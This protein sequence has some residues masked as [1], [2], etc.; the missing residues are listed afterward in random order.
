MIVVL[1]SKTA[2]CK[3][4][5]T[6]NGAVSIVAKYSKKF[7]TSLL[8]QLVVLSQ[9][10]FAYNDIVPPQ[11]T[12]DNPVNHIVIDPN[13]AGNAFIDR[14]QNGTPVVNINA[15]SAGGVSANYYR[16][17]NVN[18]ENL[19][20]NN[21][22]GEAG[23]SQL[24]GALHGNPNF[25]IPG[26][27]AADIILNEVTSNRV[28]NINGYTEVFGKT[29]EVIIAN[30]NGIMVGGAGFINT[31]RLSLITGQSNGLNTYGGL[32][33]FIISTSPNAVISV[34]GRDVTDKDGNPVAY[35]LGIDM[36]DGNYMDLISRVVEINGKLLASDEINIKTGNDKAIRTANGWD[37]SSNDKESE[38]EFVI[39]STAMGGIYAGRINLIATQAGVGVR[40]RG[41]V[42]SNISDVKF[43]ADGNIVV[44]GGINSA[45]NINISTN[46]DINITGKNV[47]ANQDIIISS[48]KNISVDT[49]I[50][51]NQNISFD[52]VN[53]LTVSSD[54]SAGNNLT[55]NAT[56]TVN[57]GTIKANNFAKLSSNTF[58]NDGGKLVSVKNLD[59]NLGSNDWISGGILQANTLNL[60]A[61]TITNVNAEISAND[62]NI[63][64]DGDFINGDTGISTILAATNDMTLN[65][66]GNITNIGTIK[67]DNNLNITVGNGVYNGLQ[68]GDQA[69]LHSGGNLII[70]ANNN[71]LNKGFIQALGTLSMKTQA[72]I[73]DDYILIPNA[74]GLP[75][76]EDTVL[77]PEWQEVYDK[78]DDTT[79]IV[80]L[81]DLLNNVKTA[82]QYY[83]VQ[84][85]LRL[86][87]IEN[88][89]NEQETGIGGIT[90]ENIAT[91]S[92]GELQSVLQ[93]ILEEN[94]VAKEW[95]IDLTDQAADINSQI[96]AQQ[97]RTDEYNTV[98]EEI[99]R[100]EYIAENG[101]DTGFVYTH[102]SRAEYAEI[103]NEEYLDF[104]TLLAGAESEAKQKRLEQIENF[105][106]VKQDL[107]EEYKSLDWASMDDSE[108]YDKLSI[109]LETDYN[110]A[111]WEIRLYA[112][113]SMDLNN[114]YLNALR[115][116]SINRNIV[117]Q[118]GIH[119]DGRIYSGGNM[120]LLSNSVLHNNK[121]ALIFS[122]SDAE[123]SVQNTLFNNTNAEGQGIFVDGNLS[124]SGVESSWLDT[125][126]NY[127][128]KIESNGNL[129]INA[130]DV[131]NYGSDSIDFSQ[132]DNSIKEA[133]EYRHYYREC[134]LGGTYPECKRPGSSFVSSTDSYF[135]RE[136]SRVISKD[137]YDQ[138]LAQGEKVT[139]TF[140]YYYVE[141]YPE[142]SAAYT[143]TK[144]NIAPR[145]NPDITV[146]TDI[147]VATMT[148]TSE[149]SILRSNRGNLSI[150][151]DNIVNYNSH[152]IGHNIDILATNL[153]N[154]NLSLN[155]NAKEYYTQRYRDCKSRVLGIC[156]D[157]HHPYR[158]WSTRIVQNITGTSPS[159]ILAQNNLTINANTIGNGTT[160]TGDTGTAE[161]KPYEPIIQPETDLQE[162]V[163]TG[164]IDPLED[165]KLPD[166]NYGLIRQGDIL[167]GEY[168]YETDPTLVDLEHYLGSKYFM[169]RIGMD[170]DDVDAKFLGDAYVEHQIIKESLDKIQSFGNKT[171]TDAETNDY[172]NG[173]YD[174]VTPE[175]VAELGLEFG[176]ALTA[177]QISQLDKDIV[178]YVKQEILLPNG[179]TVEVLVP[180]VFLA[181]NTV[182]EL[183]G[184]ALARADIKSSIRGDN[185]TIEAL[186]DAA[187]T[188]LNNSGAIVGNRNLV[189]TTDQINNSAVTV[190]Y[191]TP[192]LHGGETL[193]LNT[194]TSGS[195]NNIG[196]LIDGGTIDI[197]T[198]DLNVHT[199]SQRETAQGYGYTSTETKIGGIAT[200][201][202]TDN[203]TI[204]TERDIN[205]TGGHISA[206]SDANLNVGGNLNTESVQDYQYTY[207]HQSSGDWI[208]S[209]ES[210]NI[211][212]SIKNIGSE[213]SAGGNMN[214]D[215]AGDATFAGTTVNAG[216]NADV[217]VGGNTN[218][219]AT[220]DYDY[221]YSNTERSSWAGLVNERDTTEDSATR[222]QGASVNVNDG[223]TLN[224]G[225]NLNIVA[226]DVNVGGDADIDAG[227]NVNVISADEVSSHYEEHEKTNLLKDVALAVAT[228]GASLL[229]DTD[230]D[231]SDGH[232][233]VSTKLGEQTRDANN[234]TATNAIGGAINVGGD[235]DMN[236]DGDVNIHG[237]DINVGGS[238]AITAAGDINVTA[239]QNTTETSSLHED[240][241]IRATATVGNAYV[242]AGYAA[243]D[244]VDA[245][246]AVV[247][248]TENLKH[249]KELR[250]Q[251]K[252][253]DAAVRDAEANLAMAT[254]NLANAE[255]G[256]V[257]SVAGA[258]SAAGTSF[259]TGLYASV[260]L[261]FDTNRNT[262]NITST[263]SV[264]SNIFGNNLTLTSGNNM[265]QIGSDVGAKDTL[266]YNI[267][268]DLNIESAHNTYSSDSGTRNIN[269][270]VTVGNNA[271]QANA[272]YNES[273]NRTNST[274]NINSNVTADNVTI[275]TGNNATF[276]GANV[277]AGGDLTVNIGGDMTVE[278]RQDTDYVSGDN[279]GINAGIGTGNA[280]GGFNTGNNNTDVAWV[281]D[282][283]ELT[284]DNVNI[285]VGGK[286]TLTG[287]VI[288]GR[289]EL[290][291]ATGELAYNDIQDFNT[292]SETGFGINSGIGGNRTDM[293][294]YNLHP[295]GST[296]ISMTDKGSTTEQTT[297]A[298]IGA[299]NITVGGDTNP[300]LAGL[301][302]DV[303]N[304]Q[305]ITRD[306]ITGALDGSVT[307]DN[308]VFTESG[309]DQIADQHENL[310]D[311]AIIAGV[312]A[313]GTVAGTAD[314]VKDVVTGE[315][316]I[317]DAAKS[318]QANQ[319]GMAT[320]I[321]RGG[322]DEAKSIIQ[323]IDT[324]TATPED[325]QA[326][327][328]MSADG[329]INLVYSDTSETITLLDKAGNE[330][331]QIA[332]SGFNDIENR[333]GYINVGNGA[334]TDAYT[335]L[336]TDAEERAHNYVG[337]NEDLA[338]SA[339]ENEMSYYNT[340][341]DW[342]GGYSVAPGQGGGG[343]NSQS[344]IN[345]NNNNENNALLNHNNAQASSVTGPRS[346]LIFGELA[347]S[348]GS[349]YY[350]ITEGVN[351]KDGKALV[352][353]NV[354]GVAVV[355]GIEKQ[356]IGT[357][358][359]T[360][361]A[362][363]ESIT[364]SLGLQW[365]GPVKT[366]AGG[367]NQGVVSL[368]GE[369]GAEITFD[370]LG[371]LGGA[372]A[373]TSAGKATKVTGNVSKIANKADDAANT[374]IKNPSTPIGSKGH[375]LDVAP[376]TN[377]SG[378]VD[379]IK[380]TGHAF[381]QMQADGIMPSVVKDVI[382]NVKPTKGKNPGTNAYY[383]PINNV[384]VITN[385]KGEIVTVS[386]GEIRQ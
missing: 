45:T 209:Q 91:L 59:I 301:N 385:A 336:R 33:P 49:P 132:F 221:N 334:G 276:A 21:L 83:R 165:F 200:I 227:G 376:G 373:L 167:N 343:L 302:R 349:P 157:Y 231:C 316:S 290:N 313:H 201:S 298:T 357:V 332:R 241:E 99:E 368:V 144:V 206:G 94:Y 178:W 190:G 63:Y 384:T 248:A 121:G 147:D 170:P 194:G 58:D 87:K 274:T 89:L 237:S 363:F 97:T 246:D 219:V 128:G 242:D 4:Y 60:T 262:N 96:A 52:T 168:L 162:I 78:L 26:A 104:D 68:I 288:D 382:D 61:G 370:A 48:N 258:A 358:V 175:L 75:D 180:Q 338:K 183:Y 271:V 174:T 320:G 275:N 238:G 22:K 383:S 120:S 90:I 318:W 38:P 88:L 325:L 23:I 213:I 138:L 342:T 224:T 108:I 347:Q 152:I 282:Q 28:S 369:N 266:T 8:A 270:S 136:T 116:N 331:G 17:F 142:L 56:N 9:S 286:T 329:S 375:P 13:R 82:E 161:Y 84:K 230:V 159:L 341:A 273:S 173:L 110:P 239:A 101:D 361:D 54:V 65:I 182:N 25:N 345:W 362:P 317:T 269:A 223:L 214:V 364:D 69:T 192:V 130:T 131:I 207:E 352:L 249:I 148:A 289:E 103:A 117:E 337:A 195:V 46:S 244:L 137:E 309:R 297:H 95:Q 187:D 333:Q 243:A 189:I 74:N 156:V 160:E 319:S 303:D 71:I 172:I 222:L 330:I 321:R 118:T 379:G 240:T 312:G 19:I 105:L 360:I 356:I 236:A 299:G 265:T 326:L 53:N 366:I 31:S 134:L 218:I 196:G 79:D 225:N 27:N 41:D 51:A 12:N 354:P 85:R 107:V 50:N 166:G 380:Y 291:L 314:V 34:I 353:E 81:S 300:E 112:D 279:F 305:E 267:G 57:S 308:R 154:S 133:H 259:G 208:S 188:I 169:N 250:D 93:M 135:S 324:G 367:I 181:Q 307:V 3:K 186:S 335:F 15:A 211:S 47:A 102:V 215:V 278:S 235:L 229:L 66:T 155:V 119:N 67:S 43:D 109:L 268:K 35:N 92:E 113:H 20:L 151:A 176:I 251:G 378:I 365:Q 293:G 344:Q 55:T 351:Y 263:E 7:L 32:N 72:Q 24:G 18:N 295:Q 177:Q 220:T 2:C 86:I 205:I 146:K 123:L 247:K 283:T 253:S 232:C 296:T 254:A 252:A 171:M 377:T 202:A 371:W 150:V 323:K 14:A 111:E 39:D 281:K 1:K 210:T 277:D 44:D 359:N 11:N 228:G 149:K 6:I 306:E 42:V 292:S 80:V 164:T 124:I 139:D 153:L 256:A 217:K 386:R 260:G 374:M 381:D 179:E 203:L 193:I 16:D 255:L 158:T 98:Q 198:G 10:A 372:K 339:A 284:G 73:N 114:A 77:A 141:D 5:V 348:L 129:T 125:L 127:D 64:A 184:S 37:V 311:N 340:V 191:Q 322:S 234:I 355:D 264:G 62:L 106:T 328:A 285:N 145:P 197:N 199:V 76:K 115:I 126:I 70:N 280:A 143:V 310:V 212:E 327:A 304:S 350:M 294:D 216:K 226:S 30:P 315:T 261:G 287:G 29:A 185:V 346:D 122:A 36:S 140:L 204:T 40:T 233:T 163:R 272:G 245:T 257:S 100:E